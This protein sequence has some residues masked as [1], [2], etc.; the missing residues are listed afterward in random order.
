MKGRF[1]LPSPATAI[2][3]IA[4]F[5][6]LSGTAVAAGIVPKA[7][8]ALN[9]GKLQGQTAAQVAAVPS[10]ASSAASLVTTKTSSFSITSQNGSVVTVACDSGQ[11]AIG[12]G[13]TSSQ[14]VL[15][16][17]HSPSSDGGSWQSLLINVDNTTA[18][19]TA[20]AVCLK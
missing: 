4:L 13:Y 11:K 3:T 1:R 6:A 16:G 10:P 17:D 14:A 19:G 2:A 5:V 12:G 20:Y 8:F 18:S 7:K 9:A 15:Q